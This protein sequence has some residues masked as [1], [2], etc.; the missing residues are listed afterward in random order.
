M[1]RLALLWVGKVA[2]VLGVT[3]GLYLVYYGYDMRQLREFCDA[4]KPG[5]LVSGLPTLAQQHNIDSRWF[6]HDGAYNADRQQ[7]IYYVPSAASVG[8][9]VCAIRHDKTQVI[10]AELQF[11]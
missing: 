9:N 8:A 5:M 2:M 7:W 1:L 6:R 11:D 10:S 3:F 4:I